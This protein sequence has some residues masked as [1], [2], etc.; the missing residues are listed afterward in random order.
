[1]P[2]MIAAFAIFAMIL[3]PLPLKASIFSSP[4]FFQLS[5]ICHAVDACHA[6]LALFSP[7]PRHAAERHELI[8]SA[9]AAPAAACRHAPPPLILAFAAIF[10]IFFIFFA[11]I[12]SSPLIFLPCSLRLRHYADDF[13]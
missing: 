4:D 1:M 11:D 7:P 3:P 8:R 12:F 9:A 5:L 2:L 10:A 13:A 6:A